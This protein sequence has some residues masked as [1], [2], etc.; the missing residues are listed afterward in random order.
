[1]KKRSCGDVRKADR[2]ALKAICDLGMTPV[3]DA[4]PQVFCQVKTGNQVV[5]REVWGKKGREIVRITYDGKSVVELQR[6]TSP[7]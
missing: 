5:Q 3:S 7:E 4:V 2:A 6:A 1:M